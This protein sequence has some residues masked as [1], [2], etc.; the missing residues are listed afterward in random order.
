MTSNYHQNKNNNIVRY[1]LHVKERAIVKW[2]TNEEKLQ[3]LEYYQELLL[4]ITTKFFPYTLV[5]KNKLTKHEV[6]KFF[7][8]FGQTFVKINIENK[9]EEGFV[10]FHFL[11]THFRMLNYKLDPDKTI[12][13]LIKQGFYP[14]LMIE[15]LKNVK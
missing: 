1:L 9:K 8:S 3:R 7:E 2:K 12:E 15:F 13:A 6:N 11:L 4:P 10:N 14:E 5:A